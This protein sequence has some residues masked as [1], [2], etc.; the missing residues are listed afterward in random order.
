MNR[1]VFGR[2]AAMALLALALAG[3]KAGDFSTSRAGFKANYLVA[4][5]ALENGQYSKA[6]RHYGSLLRK[7]GPLEP[8]LRLEFAH[9]LLREGKY[10]KA[11]DE[12]RTVAMQL[13]G[14]GRSA[15]LAV[16]G[17]AE[18]EAARVAVRT[19]KTGLATAKLMKSAKAALEEML[20]ANPELDATGGMA[21]RIGQIETEL[22]TAL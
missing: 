10:R 3:C 14:A 7:A 11:A 21:A 5:V 18:H 16:Q 13:S 12:A 9:A 22:R 19:G 2:N 4:R 15:A 8:R 6:T 20:R 17:T 1:A